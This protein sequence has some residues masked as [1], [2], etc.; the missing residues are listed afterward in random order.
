MNLLIVHLLAGLS[1]LSPEPAAD[2]SG[3]EVPKSNV[4]FT[5]FDRYEAAAIE[6]AY[7]HVTGSQATFDR[8]AADDYAEFS[9]WDYP[10]N[11]GCWIGDWLVSCEKNANTGDEWDCGV[12][13]HDD[14]D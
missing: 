10:G 1:L 2:K 8:L 13:H 14:L 3:T 7:V 9:C 6:G 4:E 5:D 11:V 12:T